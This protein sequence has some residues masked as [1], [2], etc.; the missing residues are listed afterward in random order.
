MTC[1]LLIKP[2]FK[3]NVTNGFAPMCSHYVHPIP[4]AESVHCSPAWQC[5]LY[6]CSVFLYMLSMKAIGDRF[7]EKGSRAYM[8]KFPIG[9]I[10][11]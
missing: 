7:C 8:T 9:A 3:N 6:T 11:M 4:T 1:V 10:E 2:L 5:N